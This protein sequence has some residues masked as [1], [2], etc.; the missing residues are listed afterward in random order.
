[1]ISDEVLDKV[2]E[3]IVDKIEK[4]NQYILKT[5]GDSIKEIGTINPTKLNQLIMSLKY[6]SN[7]KSMLRELSKYTKISQK[8]I[9]AI[10]EEV[11]KSDYKFAKQFYEYRDRPY[12]PYNQNKELVEQTKELA[13]ITA[14]ECINLTRTSALGFGLPDKDGN[15]VYHGI[16]ETYYNLLDEAVLSIS[17]GKE[18]FD[19]AMYRQLKNIAE[20]GLKVVYPT[21]YIDKNGIERHYTRRL[22][23]AIRMNLK[24]GLRQLH[25]ETQKTIGEQIDADGVEISVHF[26]PAEDHAE[27]QG[28]QFTK[29]EYDK[30]QSTGVAK[31][32]DGIHIDM[33]RQ[34]KD[35][36][37][38]PSFRP[39]SEYN[40]YHYIFSIVLGVNRPQYSNKQLKKI[41]D[42]NLKG[43][44]FEGNHYTM[45]EGTQLQ[46]QIETEIRKAKESKMIGE[47]AGNEQLILESQ[48]KIRMLSKKYR[49]LSNASG[50][51]T[52][53][54]RMRI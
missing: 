11:A 25:N 7:Y 12:V 1:M 39:I 45:Y 49:E 51:Q 30:L 46:R 16:K 24:S 2:I 20:S 37:D 54:D 41:N 4:A 3:R 29:K 17:Q 13:K 34:L 35:G 43:F 15:I 8:E 21:T 14:N 31:S 53:A 44:E 47:K 5:I 26:N 33:H 28:K 40:C 32:Y 19:S 50:L 48:Q 38:A 36:S 9:N 22:D 23:S 10:F 27:A 18:T 42:D 52:R 6:G